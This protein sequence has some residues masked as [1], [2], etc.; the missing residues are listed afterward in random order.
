M[1]KTDCNA[2]HTLN[3]LKSKLDDSSHLTVLQEGRYCWNAHFTFGEPATP[4]SIERIKEKLQLPFSP[5]Y[6]EFLLSANGALLYHDNVNGQWGFR[7]YGTRE[8][9]RANA[10]FKERYRIDHS[11]YIAFAESLGD[12]DLLLLDTT[13]FVNEG[14]DFRVIDGDSADPPAQWK[15][16]ARSF[17]DWLDRLVVAQGA[18]YWRWY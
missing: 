7:L 10:R 8:L 15:T 5:A 11:S 16:A 12:A 1:V 3:M 13:Q 6:E 2:V 4:E 17:C 18:K 14:R 9:F